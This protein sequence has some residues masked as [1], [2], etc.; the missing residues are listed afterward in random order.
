[1][2]IEEAQARLQELK[3]LQD[4]HCTCEI[5]YHVRLYMVKRIED[6]Q[7]FIDEYFRVNEILNQEYNK[8]N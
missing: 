2:T 5:C 7:R 8:N 4:V 6:L 3:M 1:M